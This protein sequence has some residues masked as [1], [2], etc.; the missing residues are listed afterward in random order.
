[1]LLGGINEASGLLK[2][3]DVFVLPSLKE[4]LP[5]TILEALQAKIPIIATRVGGV[6]E[7]LQKNKNVRIINPNNVPELSKALLGYKNLN[8][9][10]NFEFK[11]R[12]NFQNF[13]NKTAEIYNSN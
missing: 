8:F 1:M 4:G 2:S 13:L 7:I 6:P 12:Q 5:Y 3:F 9:N 10:K 11:T